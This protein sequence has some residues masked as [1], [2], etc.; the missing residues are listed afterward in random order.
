MSGALVLTP[1]E[2]IKDDLL[3]NV[4]HVPFKETIDWNYALQNIDAKKARNKVIRFGI[5][6]FVKKILVVMSRIDYLRE[7]NFEFKNSHN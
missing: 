3:K 4:H 2:Y 1:E 5:N 7:T 6:N